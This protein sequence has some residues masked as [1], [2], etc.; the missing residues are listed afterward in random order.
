MAP[1]KRSAMALARGA[2]TGDLMTVAFACSPTS[3]QEQRRVLLLARSEQSCAVT[4]VRDALALRSV[5]QID[6]QRL[7]L[8]DGIRVSGTGRTNS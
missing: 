3:D 4:A 5:P 7:L 6:R 2:R 8:P 1:R